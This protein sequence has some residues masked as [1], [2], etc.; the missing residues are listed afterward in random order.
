M[1]TPPAVLDLFHSLADPGSAE[2]RRRAGALGLLNRLRLRNVHFESHRAALVE[3][4]GGSVLP[5]L[6]D[7][8]TL[9]QGLGPVLAALENVSG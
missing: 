9:H 8:R 2:A 4:G 7:G 6:W 3:L 1:A 5:A